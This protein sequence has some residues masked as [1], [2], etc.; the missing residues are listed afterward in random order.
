MVQPMVT[1]Y[2]FI[3]WRI[4]G[5]RG[6]HAMRKVHFGFFNASTPDEVAAHAR[7]TYDAYYREIR[8][9][10]PPERRLEY[11]MGD[12]WEPLCAFLGV[13]VPEGVEFP[14]ENDKASHEKEGAERLKQIYTSFAKVAIPCAIG[15]AAVA[16]GWMYL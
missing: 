16:V 13:P 4:M 9:Q 14:R 12:G 10:V 3:L 7:Q 6:V 11:K 1:I 8:K 2:A 5:I 15:C